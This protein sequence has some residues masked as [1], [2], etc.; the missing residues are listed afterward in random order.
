M[1]NWII[2]RDPGCVPDRKG[3]FPDHLLKQYLR[4]ALE[5]RMGSMIYWSNGWGNGEVLEQLPPHVTTA[6]ALILNPMQGRCEE[7]RVIAASDSREELKAAWDAEKVEPYRDGQWYRSYRK[8]GPLEWFNPPM[9]GDTDF[10]N[11]I[12]E[13]RRDGWRRV[14]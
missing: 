14:A 6:F 9:G 10:R 4:E 5:A 1:S 3:P 11:G 7:Q 12:I 8:G 2:I 13:L